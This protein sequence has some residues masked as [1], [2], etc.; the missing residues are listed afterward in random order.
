MILQEN[1]MFDIFCY[2]VVVGT[3][4]AALTFTFY[5]LDFMRIPEP[6]KQV[7]LAITVAKTK[8]KRRCRILRH[9][10]YDFAVYGPE[11]QCTICF[12]LLI[13]V[14]LS[15]SAFTCSCCWSVSLNAPR[16]SSWVNTKNIS[17]CNQTENTYLK[18]FCLRIATIENQ[19]PWTFTYIHTCITF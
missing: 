1:I 5:L 8:T 7:K 14:P 9:V 6:L 15:P 4:W 2:F 19:K 16:A 18:W 13:S 11:N 3:D 10:L 17:K 12:S